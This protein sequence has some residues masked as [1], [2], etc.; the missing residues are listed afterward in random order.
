MSFCVPLL[1]L[2]VFMETTEDTRVNCF[3]D[4]DELLLCSK[5][6]TSCMCGIVALNSVDDSSY[7]VDMPL[8]YVYSFC[9]EAR[10]NVSFAYIDCSF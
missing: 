8:F 9:V 3:L 4:D 1:L 6:A 10:A 2:L 5:R 7:T